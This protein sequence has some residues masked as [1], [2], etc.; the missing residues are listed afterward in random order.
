MQEKNTKTTTGD[1][2]KEF[3]LMRTDTIQLWLWLEGH[4][5]MDEH[6]LK[7]MSEDVSYRIRETADVILYLHL[8]HSLLILNQI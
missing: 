7:Y 6:C 1:H 5:P 2:E 3:S 8:N 4:H